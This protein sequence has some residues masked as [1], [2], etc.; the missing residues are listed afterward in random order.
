MGL[1]DRVGRVISSNFNA[2][3]DRVDDPGKSVDQILLD[4]REQ[5][6]AARAEVVRAVA[7]EKQLRG[8]GE[9]LDAESTRWEERAS[10]ALSHGDEA[11][12]REALAQKR[13]VVAERDRAEA[14]RA[15]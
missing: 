2:L 8:K 13:R 12:A 10:L 4:M 3:L 5:L 11:L 14:L 6:R 15:E 1:I 9:A 7:M